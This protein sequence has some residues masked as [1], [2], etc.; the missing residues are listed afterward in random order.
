[1]LDRTKQ[2]YDTVV[3]VTI[4][5]EESWPKVCKGFMPKYAFIANDHG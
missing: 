3:K 4:L 5:Q 1:M 2:I